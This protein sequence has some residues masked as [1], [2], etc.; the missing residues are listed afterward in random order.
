MGVSTHSIV[1][2]FPC[3]EDTP[4]LVFCVHFESR[5]QW[6]QYSVNNKRLEDAIRSSVH[7]PHAYK[8]GYEMLQQQ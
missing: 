5:S 8:E 2:H 4:D 7:L 6:K 1:S 3:Q